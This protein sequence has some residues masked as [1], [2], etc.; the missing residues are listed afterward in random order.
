M[1]RDMDFD[2]RPLQRQGHHQA[3][4]DDITLRTTDD[5]Q[6]G[7]DAFDIGPSDGIGSLDYNDFELG[8][9][10]DGEA[11]SEPHDRSEMMS[12]DGSVGVGRDAHLRRDSLDSGQFARNG[13]SAELDAFSLGQKSREASEVPFGMDMN[14]DIPGVDLTEFGVGFDNILPPEENVPSLDVIPTLSKACE[15]FFLVC[16]AQILSWFQR[17]PSLKFLPHHLLLKTSKWMHDLE[18][19]VQ[20]KLRRQRSAQRIR[21]R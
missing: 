18:S 4:V 15:S 9:D 19:P 12:V 8:I 2:D 10:W 5:F 14:L 7:G 21:S 17:L 13:F 11:R 6:L 3:H 1:D 20:K 16:Y